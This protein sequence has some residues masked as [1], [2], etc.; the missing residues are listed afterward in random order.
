M[1]RLRLRHLFYRVNKS[2]DA[3]CI[4]GTRVLDFALSRIGKSKE[5]IATVEMFRQKPKRGDT[6]WL[7]TQSVTNQSPRKIP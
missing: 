2:S 4:A 1:P 3:K 5:S 6:G 7:T